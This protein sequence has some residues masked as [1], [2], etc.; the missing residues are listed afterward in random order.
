M[1]SRLPQHGH[2]QSSP[3]HSPYPK[4]TLLLQLPAPCPTSVLLK[5]ARYSVELMAELPGKP[6]TATLNPRLAYLASR[7]S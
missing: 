2:N 6:G 1:L 3:Q 4:L 5:G 7:A